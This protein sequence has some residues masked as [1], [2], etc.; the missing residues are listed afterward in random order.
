MEAALL[1]RRRA[2]A[3][4][5][6]TTSIALAL[7]CASCGGGT[8]R[9][10]TSA[11]VHVAAAPAI[12]VQPQSQAVA[13]GQTAAFSVSATGTAPLRFQWR[14]N[15][16]NIAG[17]TAATYI[18]PATTGDTSGATFDVVVTNGMGSATSS[19]AR[20]IVNSG[21]PAL[22]FSPGSVFFGTQAVGAGGATP[23]PVQLSNSGTAALTIT[24][25]LMIGPN[26]SDFGLS[27]SCPG[28]LAAGA[29]C[30]LN[31]SFTPVSGGPRRVGIAVTDNAAGS[32]HTLIV[33]GVG[34]SLGLSAVTLGFTPQDVGTA[35]ALHSLTVTNKGGAAV[36]LWQM[37]V[38]GANAGD[39]PNS[40][41]CGGTLASN[42]SC[43]VTVSF[44]PTAA[45]AR[46]A[47][48][49]I[50]N[51]GGGSPE[52]VPLSGTGN[53]P[54][55]IVVSPQ[56]AVIAD[57][58]G[59]PATQAYTATGYFGD[60]TAHDLTALVTWASTNPAVAT[61]NAAGTATSQTLGSGQTA[62]F[63][64]ITASMN[65][66]R[67]T[68]ILSVTSHTGNGFAG[69]FTQHNDNARTGQNLHE[70]A[71]TPAIVG[72]IAT[73]GKK[74]SLAVDG[75][76][77]AQ[78]LYVPNVPI[79]GKG[80]HNVVFV[81]TE[82]DTVYALDA[83]SNTGP[84]ATPL[85]QA[86]MID[87]VNHG[88][89]VGETTVSSAD[90]SCGDLSPEIGITS[91]PVIDPSTNTLYA[92]AK[93]KLK[94]G[95]FI[96][97]LHALDITS[98]NE[99]AGSPVAITASVPG[100]GEGGSTIVFNSLRQ[101]NRPGLLLVNGLV[102]L[103]YA[104]HCDNGP[105]HGWIFAY[106][107]ATLT[108]KSV[109]NTTPNGGLGGI[110]MSGTGLAA[111]DQVNIF[112]ATGNGTFDTTGTVVDFGDT[113][114]KVRLNNGA[115][116]L[117][118]YFT[119]FNQASLSAADNDLGSGGT[120]LLPDQPGAH[121]HLLVQ[122]G[123]EGRI[124]LIDRDQMTAGNQHYCNGCA[125]DTQIVQE[126]PS[127]NTGTWS[128]P[129]YWNG[130]LYFC[131]QSGPLQQFKLSSGLLTPLVGISAIT[132]HYPGAT[133]AV[134]ANGTSNAIVW[135]IDYVTGASPAVLHAY[136]ATRL[137]TELYNTTHAPGN[138]DQAGNGVKFSVPTIANGKVYIGTTAGLYVYGP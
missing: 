32:P 71:L 105:Y 118:D 114:F 119:P 115:L 36:N 21:T 82:H 64:S 113:I 111:D 19:P 122:S 33:T 108:Q 133:P 8:P 83:D 98:G 12:V 136:D 132:F 128:S 107:A 37:A 20:L 57:P 63:T 47:S 76:I 30:T 59:S 92:E 5:L 2:N 103:A 89:T 4:L 94:D 52:S 69:V 135:V 87:A 58:G 25:I 14:Q 48:L 109:F 73:F 117:T 85:W 53:A 80:T 67:G 35:S 104:S 6:A 126:M 40:T 101:M 79:A 86:S 125:S 138:R 78:P 34:S 60:G 7:W 11:D 81:A 84:N 97:R 16:A 116:A 129:A 38:L 102:Y 23:T 51:D 28:T 70:T 74:F 29:N 123:K 131:G 45:G 41:T 65:S 18:T 100:T 13:A 93:S 3:G 127:A 91:T 112:A 120:V 106:D 27:Q 46:S 39:F 15:G 62:A 50:S 9:L 124:Y 10:M 130:N 134:S 75:Q 68:A 56:N 55:A 43:N 95:T 99:M 90:V 137:S 72:N 121:P 54:T 26:N 42:A 88:A 1:Q 17:A 24:S 96:H 66:V 77:Y 49:L 61:V 110:W 22:A 31:I 44:Q